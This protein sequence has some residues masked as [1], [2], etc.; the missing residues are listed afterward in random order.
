[1][2]FDALIKS[3]NLR[4]ASRAV[5]EAERLGFKGV[6]TN[7]TA[8]DPF[9]PLA[10]ASLLTSRVQM[11]TAVAIA[12]PRSPT[13]TAYTAWDLAQASE[14]RF[15]L[16][17]G[18][19]VKAHIERRFSATWDAPV[20]RLRDYIGA[21]RAVWDCWQTGER[22]RYESPHY[23]LKLMTPFF[24]P[25]PL[26]DPAHRPPIYIAGVNKG[27]CRLAGE[28]C[29]GFHVHP[30]HSI[31]YLREAVLPW[32]GEGLARSGRR[33]TDM[34]VCMSVFAITV[35][36]QARAE[37]RKQLAFYASTPSY[38]TLLEMH[39]WGDTGIELGQLATRGKWDDMGAL[40]TDDM[41][42]Q[43]AVEADTLAGAVALI[44]ERYAGLADRVMLYTPFVAG[45]R[46]A[47]WQA[48]VEAF[49]V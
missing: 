38:R 12:F 20:E 16:G 45:E 44:K 15:I 9:L 10:P 18:T 7:E 5:Q 49:G 41:L 4:E 25:P 42:E 29:D 34:Q 47:E 13:V 33:R 23:N 6:W 2:K 11:G 30:F 22:L 27:L 35:G 48:A 28:V 32:I 3:D 46:D 31:R 37:T 21:V 36:K 40:I 1:M 39:G 14:G 43:F 8:H 24:S 19:Q 17:L 26:A